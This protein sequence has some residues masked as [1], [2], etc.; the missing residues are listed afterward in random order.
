MI[1]RMTTLPT[2]NL[3]PETTSTTIIA[4]KRGSWKD[5]R[6]ALGKLHLPNVT[7]N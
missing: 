1:N 4:T 2:S 7:G 6:A 3:R 5:G